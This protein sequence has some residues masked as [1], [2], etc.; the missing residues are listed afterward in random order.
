LNVAETTRSFLTVSW[1]G[2]FL[3]TWALKSAIRLKT[4]TARNPV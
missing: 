2:G 3:G 4:R 1:L